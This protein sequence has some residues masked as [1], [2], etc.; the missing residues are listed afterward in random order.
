M[1]N[2][3]GSQPSRGRRGVH[4]QKNE[5]YKLP[6]IIVLNEDSALI[7]LDIAQTPES[8]TWRD[9]LKRKFPNL[10]L[11]ESEKRILNQIETMKQRKYYIIVAGRIR[12][13]TLRSMTETAK[14]RGTY[15]CLEETNFGQYSKSSK[16]KGFFN[17]QAALKQAIY[18]DVRLD[19]AY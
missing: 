3:C 18:Y 17:T 6:K 16:I 5:R 13:E 14:V 4:E 12:Q 10:I 7:Y 19:A 1:G 8:T 15:F 2:C 11:C 9:E